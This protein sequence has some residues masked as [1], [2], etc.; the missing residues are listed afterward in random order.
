MIKKNSTHLYYVLFDCGFILLLINKFARVI[1]IFT[2]TIFSTNYIYLVGIF[3]VVLSVLI[4]RFSWIDLLLVA[5]GYFTF[6]SVHDATLFSFFVLLIATQNINTDDILRI[7][8]RVQTFILSACIIV[9]PILLVLGSSYATVSYSAGRSAIRYNFFFSHPNNFAIQ[10]VFTVL[11]YI[12]LYRDKLSYYKTNIIIL[13]TIVFLLV[14]P[15]SKTAVI[16]LI[17]YLVV[18][19]MIKYAKLIWKPFIKFVFP[20]IIICISILV[21]MNYKG[22]ALPFANYITG[23]FAA[24]FSGAAMSFHIYKVNLF[25]NYLNEIGNTIYINGQWSTLWIDLAY[26]RMLI[27]FGIVGASIFYYIFFK[28]LIRHIKEK[29]YTVL[30]LFVVVIVYAIAEWTA[31]SILTVFPLLFCNIS[32]QSRSKKS[33]LKK[34]RIKVR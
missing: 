5:Y 12:Y 31:F 3:L 23:T 28:G 22:M 10:C 4:K 19:F 26:I 29:N 9:Y 1:N 27:A 11:V 20:I 13:F 18:L 33:V 30:S 14:F 21:Y 2:N 7:Y 34:M 24:R 17:I 15:K 25:G 16:A 8:A 6:I 32:F